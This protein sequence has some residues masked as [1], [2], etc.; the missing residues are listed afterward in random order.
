[1]RLVGNVEAKD[2]AKASELVQLPFR[3]EGVVTTTLIAVVC[4][5]PIIGDSLHPYL[6]KHL[7]IL[8]LCGQLVVPVA[9]ESSALLKARYPGCCF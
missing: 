9:H 8:A 7:W 3:R 4:E 2:V 6:V 5:A 1:M